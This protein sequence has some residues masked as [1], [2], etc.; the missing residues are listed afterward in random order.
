M[1]LI[2]GATGLL[3]SHIAEQL[4]ARGHQV[5]ALVRRHS[6]RQFL[7]ALGVN[8]MDGDLSDPSSL[9][10]ATQGVDTVFHAAARVGE[11]GPWSEFQRHT[12]TGTGNVVDACL[13]CR[14]RRLVHIS[15]TSAYGHPLPR[16]GGITEEEPLGTRLWWWDCYT[17]AKVA[18]EEIVWEAHKTQGLSITVIRPGWIYGPRDRS[19]IHR[20]A[21]ALRRGH[22]PIIGRGDNLL[23]IVYAG[24]VAE[25]CLL[26]A[27]SEAA[28]GQAYNISHDGPITQRAFLELLARELELPPPR[29]HIPF[30]LAFS[31]AFLMEAIGRTLHIP[32]PPPLTRYATWYLGKHLPH[33]TVK[34]ETELG[35]KP[36]VGYEEGIRRM[37]QW[38]K[39]PI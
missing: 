10:R 6:D 20:L 32:K 27:Q 24:N 36:S 31:G 16:P 25:A 29:W 21:E 3:G 30:G 14:V 5:R 8:C 7:D 12:V 34:I 19:R 26:A 35:W 11:W 9:V 23:N 4:A 1:H 18:A 17:R 39:S 22:M 33:S 28:A 15:S 38:S 37:V 2:T 13:A